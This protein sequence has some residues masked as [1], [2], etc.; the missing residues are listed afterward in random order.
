L[1]I[2]FIG[3]HGVVPLAGFV[4]SAVEQEILTSSCSA[5]G[6]MLLTIVIAN[7][8]HTRMLV[9]GHIS[10]QSIQDATAVILLSLEMA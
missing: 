1:Q 7:I 4:R 5:K 6:V 3:V 9:L 10:A 8:L 2:Y